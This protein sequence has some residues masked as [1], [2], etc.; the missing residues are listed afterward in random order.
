MSAGKALRVPAAVRRMRAVRPA[1]S[2]GGTAVAQQATAIP[3]AREWR[4]NGRE[5]I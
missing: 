2:G 5:A 4:V 1:V 3:V